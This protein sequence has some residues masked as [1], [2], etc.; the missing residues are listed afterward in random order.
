MVQ[1]DVVVK[2]LQQER[3]HFFDA[4]VQLRCLSDK[5]KSRPSMLHMG[6]FFGW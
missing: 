4:V 3:M 5:A 6:A 2:M 1:V